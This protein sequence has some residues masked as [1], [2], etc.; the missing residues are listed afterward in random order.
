MTL[1]EALTVI[2]DVNSIYNLDTDRYVYSSMTRSTIPE[3]A[4][5]LIV[6]EIYAD[7]GINI[8]VRNN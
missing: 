1:R 2:E 4:L 3:E 6:D 8:T 7:C 5:D